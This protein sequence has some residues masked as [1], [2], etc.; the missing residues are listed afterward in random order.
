MVNSVIPAADAAVAQKAVAAKAPEAQASVAASP[1]PVKQ[2]G[3]SERS[4]AVVV[5]LSD[6]AQAKQLKTEGYSVMEIST[7][8]GLDED[9][10]S[11]Y[12]SVKA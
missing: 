7:K 9:T 2:S 1:A 8:L 6:A 3:E 11:S 4:A 10:V 5:Q 12:L